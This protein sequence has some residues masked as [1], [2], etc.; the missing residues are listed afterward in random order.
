[1]KICVIF[2][3]AAHGEKAGKF[4]KLI[5]ALSRECVLKPT[6]GA[7]TARP[8]AAEA[9]REGFDTIV[10]AGGDGT[11]N[12]VLNGI[13]DA[14]RGFEK[15]RLAVLPL[16]TVNVFAKELGLPARPQDAWSSIQEGR[17]VLIDVI[18]VDFDGDTG[19]FQRFFVQMAGAGWDA[20]A[21]EK[22]NWEW[23]RKIGALAYVAAGLKALKGP[24]PR[25]VVECKSQR[26]EGELVL[27]GNGAYYGGRWRLFPQANLRD[28][29][30]EVS[31]FPR[32]NWFRMLRG[33]IGL[34]AGRLYDL[35][36]VRH[37]RGIRAHLTSQLP[38]LFHVEGEN[39]G[40]LPATFTIENRKLRVVVP[41]DSISRLSSRSYAHASR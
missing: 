8:L 3:P 39:A 15:A 38:A 34:L 10:A 19:P 30:L 36:G 23:K 5:V 9:V 41:R 13:A 17:E 14:D 32:M 21:V 35:G 2:N 11:V 16:G 4:H 33:G 22:V 24:L 26:I 25:I 7:G 1:M 29:L 20:L 18:R 6:V 37:L 28:G 31:V 27:V 40:R 12:E